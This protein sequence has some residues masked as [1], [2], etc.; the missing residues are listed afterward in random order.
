MYIDQSAFPFHFKEKRNP[1]KIFCCLS[2][3]SS[4]CLSRAFISRT[5]G[6]MELELKPYTQIYTIKGIN[7][8]RVFPV[9]LEL[10]NLAASI[11]ST[12]S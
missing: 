7:M 3:H 5:L 8:N 10:S 11:Y 12:S 6:D 2:D 1:D 4:A 9:D